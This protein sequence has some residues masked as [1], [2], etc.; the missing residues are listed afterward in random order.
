M[1]IRNKLISLKNNKN[2]DFVI[3]L[4]PG[5]KK[6]EV[7]GIKNP[8][9]RNLVKTYK[10]DPEHIK[11]MNDLPHRFHD[12]NMLHSL[13]I[14]EIKDY[15]LCVKEIN[16]FLPYISNWMV[17]DILSP[18]KAFIKNKDKA[19]KDINRWMRSKNTYT[20]RVALQL[21]MNFYLD[22]DFKEEYLVYPS[23]I[24]SKEYYV[25]MMIAWF[26]A[27]ALAKQ[28]KS[29]IKYIEN[30]KLDK[31]TH[32]KTIQK[33]IESYRIS[34]KQKEYLRTLKIK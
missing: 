16:N 15:D 14:N 7:L 29:T 34:S 31:W 5:L 20:I 27:T 26:F 12:E 3:K 22:E 10:D 4:T 32:N 6:T 1:N 33:A 23:K 21:L 25:N 9:L 2:I 13:L 11:F 24:R 8:I 28:Y 17:S 19:I 18:K 30:R